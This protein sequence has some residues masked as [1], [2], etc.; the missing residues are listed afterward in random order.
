MTCPSE[1]VRFGS[2]AAYRPGRPGSEDTA[3]TRQG[4]EL[5]MDLKYSVPELVTLVERTGDG[6]KTSRGSTGT[7]SVRD[8]T[9]IGSALG[10]D[11]ERHLM[12]WA[13]FMIGSGIC[14][15]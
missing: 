12:P 15:N 9:G 5:V 6:G 4:W 10:L 11:G 8:D 14:T 13:P 7:P 2:V 3:M 1:S